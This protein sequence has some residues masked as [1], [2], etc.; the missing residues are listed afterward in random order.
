MYF[1][2]GLRVLAQKNPP[3]GITHG[4]L[5]ILAIFL[6]HEQK[7]VFILKSSL[8]LGFIYSKCGVTTALSKV[9][10]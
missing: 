5:A 10:K 2:L 3:I 7:T 4:V 9:E 1:Y 8:N 6:L